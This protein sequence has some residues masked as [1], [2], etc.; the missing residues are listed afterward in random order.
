MSVVSRTLSG[1]ALFAFGAFIIYQ[2]V[3]EGTDI[4]S[5]VWG[6]AW[7]V[8]LCGIAVYLFLN[9]KEDEI[10]EIKSREK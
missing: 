1:I 4:W 5:F 10:E 9:K 3:T 8:F 6:L 7:G 2:T